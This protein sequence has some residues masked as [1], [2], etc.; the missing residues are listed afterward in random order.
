MSQLTLEGGS[1]VAIAIERIRF[2]APRTQPLWLAQSYGKD[3]IVMERLVRLSGVP[4]ESHHNVVGVE[5]PELIQFGRKHY[6]GTHWDMPERSMFDLV[7]TNG[8]PT[9]MHRWCCRELKE[10]GGAGRTVV[11][12]IR[13][14]ESNKRRHRSVYEACYRDNS[15]HFINPVVDWTAKDVWAFIGEYQLPYCELY[16]QGFKRLGC[17]LCPNN[18]KV[19]TQ[20]HLVR[21]PKIAEAWKRA[22]I[23]SWERQTGG[24]KAWPTGESYWKWWLTRTRQPVK[25]D[26]PTLFTM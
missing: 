6:P 8:L 9:R 20:R 22:G 13:A 24:M 17:I 25:N 26:D 12:G 10:R 2:N 1:K 14:Q 5:P 15:R 7:V 23:R 16:D 18:G 21:W 3:S 4:F 11:T 19:S